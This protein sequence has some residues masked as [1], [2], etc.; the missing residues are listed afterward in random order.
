MLPVSAALTIICWALYGA[1]GLE[2]FLHLG[3]AL[4]ISL[5]AA[6]SIWMERRE[7]AGYNLAASGILAF[8]LVSTGTSLAWVSMPLPGVAQPIGVALS[9]LVALDVTSITIFASLAAVTRNSRSAEDT[10]RDPATI[11]TGSLLG[12]VLIGGGL[13]SAWIGMKTDASLRSEVLTQTR[14]AAQ[15]IDAISVM[16]LA[17]DESD[18]ES[19]VYQSIKRK[20]E[21]VRSA[22]PMFRFVY[23]M[24][25]RGSVVYFLV[26]SEHSGSKDYSPPGQVYSDAS[27]EMLETLTKG[28]EI[29][30]GPATDRW[31][32][33]I[34]AYIP[35]RDPV[36][37]NVAALLGTDVD[38]SE[39]SR[40]IFEARRQPILGVMFVTLLAVV[41]LLERRIER[42]SSARVA[43]SERRLTYALEASNEGIWDWDMR[44]GHTVYSPHWAAS[45]GYTIG[46]IPPLA[47][48]RETMVHED[49][50][51]ASNGA[52]EAHLGGEAPCYEC[53]IR[54]RR[55]DGGFSYTLDRGTVVE[56]DPEGVPVRMVGTFTDISVRKEM[57]R[58][59]RAREEQYRQLVDNASDIIV[60]TDAHGVI[61]FINPACERLL[62]Y[63][64]LEMTGR[65]YLDFIIPEFRSGFA[66]TMARQSA[67][68]IPG[69]YFELRLAAR[70]G[71]EVW[72]GL[73][74]RLLTSDR[75]VTGFHVIARDI[76]ERRRVEE[77]LRESE[78]RLH[79]VYDHVQAGIILIDPATHTIVGANRLAAKMCGTTP[80]VMQGKICHEYMCPSQTGRCPITEMNDK[81]EN[82]QRVLLA[83][84]GAEVPILK[85]VIP[86]QISGRDYLLES[87][88]DISDRKRAEE[89][90]VRTN[91]ELEKAN[92]LLEQA[93]MKSLEMTIAA[94]A[95]S[96]AK[97]LFLANMSHEI[98]TP[99]N[100]VIGMCELLGA[101]DLT[102]EQARYVEIIHKS[103]DALVDL[104]NN[105][106]DFS[107]IEA[108]R[109]E[110]EDTDFDLRVLLE[111]IMELLS[112]RASEKGIELACII[113]PDVPVL[114]RGD[115]GRL[116]Q[117]ITN[118]AGN[119]VKFTGEGEV[120]LGVQLIERSGRE[121]SLGFRVHDTGIGIPKDKIG[122]LFDAFT[123]ADPSNTRK[124]GGTGLGL[125][126]S[127]RLV[128]L[129]RGGIHVDSEEGKGSTF[130]F[131]ATFGMKDPQGHADSV[132][133]EKLYGRRILIVE[134]NA[135]GRRAIGSMLDSQGIRHED[136]A[137]GGEALSAIEQAILA[138]D[139]FD[140]AI[141][142]SFP[143]DM[144][145]KDLGRRIRNSPVNR[146][147]FL[148]MLY[149]LAQRGEASRMDAAVFDAYLTKPLRQS[150]LLNCLRAALDPSSSRH[151]DG[152]AAAVYTPHAVPGQKGHDLHMLLVEDNPTNQMVALGILKNLGYTA[153]VAS[154]GLE[155]VKALETTRYDLVFMDCQMPV[156]DGFKATSIIRDPSS[157]V[158]DHN[159]PV[160]AM[161]AHAMNDDRRRCLEAGMDDYISKPI[162]TLELAALIQRWIERQGAHDSAPGQ[163]GGGHVGLPG[164]AHDAD[165]D[166]AHGG[167]RMVF[168]Q[169]GLMERLSGDIGLARMVVEAFV[170]DFPAMLEKIERSLI[171]NDPAGVT[172]HAHAMKGAA[173]N[174]GAVAIRDASLLL[175]EA[176]RSGDASQASDILSGLHRQFDLFIKT[177]EQNGWLSYH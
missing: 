51:Q 49:D 73:N 3:L 154:N 115:P 8:S 30:E 42:I 94:E 114:L 171:S 62:G 65:S 128:E 36:T 107:K 118:L 63:T 25:K 160:I 78:E 68:K 126:I 159:V 161:T 48:L 58:D 123:Q 165:D 152:P 6:G 143:L 87:F 45:L 176:A 84:D 149:S 50:R 120:C 101:T 10:K 5:W 173:G 167:I 17:G 86:V 80:E 132:H 24:A 20:L 177:A 172:L 7:N 98:R 74:T 59:L 162:R 95:A 108:D 31:G 22:N 56:R 135:T 102:A 91:E 138:G 131:T 69:T 15:S 16:G 89:A 53:E 141:I 119:A 81:I 85:T 116:R 112:I 137:T 52:L 145:G 96:H 90:L 148:V 21:A 93:N 23:M 41:F 79:A 146:D 136:V 55:K 72:V 46:E 19:P 168:D 39:W 54:I 104:I 110:L 64:T 158:M 38:A 28:I 140:L 113:E 133:A 174:S 67:Q 155:A 156:M 12:V 26:D 13:A 57:E 144:S 33:W 134:G 43:S 18:L 157:A 130:T 29:T 88:V 122:T 32:T 97:S 109:I 163:D 34:S 139:P 103:G 27:T 60:K 125:T 76:T 117:V 66:E 82:S 111:D 75:A 147:I 4:P 127:R 164:P 99:M 142:D 11:W 121:V 61:T 124:Y 2:Y 14:I 37:G 169:E 105:I 71:R 40:K 153:D 70:D 129:M 170:S 77:A 175:E 150:L 44:T 151:T 9:L 92:R 83:N 1:R 106:L 47:V 100:A 35:L 166:Q